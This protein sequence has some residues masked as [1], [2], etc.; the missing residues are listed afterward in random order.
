MTEKQKYL[1]TV[2]APH[3][4]AVE[5]IE[6]LDKLLDEI[7]AVEQYATLPNGDEINVTTGDWLEG[8]IQTFEEI[9]E[10]K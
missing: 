9:K 7:K 4:S 1:A 6:K 5:I 3:M 10:K 8:L 2:D